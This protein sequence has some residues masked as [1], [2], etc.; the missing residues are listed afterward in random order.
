MSHRSPEFETILREAEE[1]LRFLL[2]VPC[3]YRVLFMA[4]GGM[5]QFAAVP[6]NLLGAHPGALHLVTGLW[7]AKAAHEMV[8]FRRLL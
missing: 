4:G 2:R 6:L 7:S 1:D 8:P 5:G 3:N